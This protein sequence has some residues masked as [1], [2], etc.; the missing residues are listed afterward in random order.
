M[1]K[2]VGRETEIGELKRLHKTRKANLVIVQGRR[3]IGKSRLVEEFA[4]GKRFY[5]FTGIAPTK[6]TNA[7]TQRNEFIR[8]LSTQTDLP[9]MISDDW[10]KL[11]HLLARE[12]KQGQVI[13]LLDEI[14]W[15]ASGDPTFLGKLKTAW[16]LYFNKNPKLMLILCGSVSSWI[17]K[18]IV[19]STAFLGRPSRIIKLEALSLSECHQFWDVAENKKNRAR[20]FG[21]SPYEKLKVLAVTGGV[22]RYLELIDPTLSAEENIRYLFFSKNSALLNEFE[23]I[24]SDTFGSRSEIYRKIITSLIKGPANLTEILRNAKK[25]KTGDYS[26]YLNDLVAAGFLARDYTWQLKTGEISKLSHYRL[27]DN[28]VRFYLRYVRPNKPK[29][30]KGLFKSRSIS[31]L[32]GWETVLSLQFE[33]LVLN[34]DHKVIQRLGLAPED[35]V[36]S[37]PFFQ[38][39]TKTQSGCQIDMAIQ[40]KFNTVY[41]CEI[42]FS[43]SILKTSIISDVREKF[44][45]LKLPRNFSIRPVLI[46]VNGVHEDVIDSGFFS[47]IIDFGELLTP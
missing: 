10:G 4:G 25:T 32:P 24:F 31:T 41:L 3:R 2:F 21:I 42:K 8:Q 46:H 19:S 20:G 40:T 17:E 16:D 5:Q 47:G 37:N 28:F 22:P 18:N 26:E 1:S 30:E 35:L 14:S 33:N 39:R 34:N 7:Q 29:I 44:L 23:H 38:R 36:F 45:R 9:E 12:T 15:M 43:K 6:D 11:F 27:K 13:I